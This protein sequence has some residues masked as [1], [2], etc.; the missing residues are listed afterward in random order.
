MAKIGS[1][2]KV[3]MERETCA[4]AA[5]PSRG[6]T[7]DDAKPKGRAQAEKRPG[8]PPV[9]PKGNVYLNLDPGVARAAQDAG[10]S[11]DGQTSRR[12][13][14]AARGGLD[15][16]ESERWRSSTAISALCRRPFR[17]TLSRPCCRG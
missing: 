17:R 2:F 3:M 13:A 5:R 4:A 8:D 9:Q 16:S 1:G 15:L 10:V 14:V 7:A 12:R 6:P 11:R